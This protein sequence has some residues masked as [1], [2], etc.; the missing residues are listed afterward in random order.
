MLLT[1]EGGDLV[2]RSYREIV[3]DYQPLTV[4]SDDVID[5]LERR[6][7]SRMANVVRSLIDKP[8]DLRREVAYQRGRAD[9]LAE[10]LKQ[11]ETPRKDSGPRSYRAGPMSDG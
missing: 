7:Q 3:D 2:R 1:R 5:F 4:T 6:G 9:R 8:E 11:Y 10:R